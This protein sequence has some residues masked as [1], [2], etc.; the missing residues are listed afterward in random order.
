MPPKPWTGTQTL[1]PSGHPHVGTLPT[2][3]ETIPIRFFETFAPPPTHPPKLQVTAVSP[4]LP[5]AAVGVLEMMD[6]K[7]WFVGCTGAV[8]AKYAVLTAAVSGWTRPTT[9]QPPTNRPNPAAL[10]AQLIRPHPLS[11]T[12]LPHT[13]SDA[14]RCTCP[15]PN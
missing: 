5:L 13:Y 12:F 6:D 10:R 1:N 7:G 8:V 3:L 11:G 14:P 9:H 4:G 2:R 15:T